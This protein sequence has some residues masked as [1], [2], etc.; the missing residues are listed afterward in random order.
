MKRKKVLLGA[1]AI[2]FFVMLLLGVLKVVG[3]TDTPEINASE[4][5]EPAG[6]EK[7]ELKLDTIHKDTDWY[8][9]HAHFHEWI[10]EEM[11]KDNNPAMCLVCHGNN[12]HAN[13]KMTRSILNMHTVFCA[14]ET[15]HFRFDPK[16]K[17]KYGFRWY[18]GSEAIQASQRHYGT[19]YDAATG[20]V[21]MENTLVNFKI[22]PFLMWE[23]KYYMVNLRQDAPEAKEYLSK[24]GTYSPEEQAAIKTK[25]HASIETKGRECSECHSVNTVIPFKKLGFDDERVK[26]LTGLNIVGMVDKYQKFYI[27]DIF[28]QKRMYDE[29]ALE[30]TVGSAERSEK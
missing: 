3:I 23:G 12:P 29:S 13:A 27:P 19:N 14:C 11:P 16:E 2:M 1:G 9:K 17:G 24:K 22:T 15:C 30:E 21:L 10:E 26:D 6:G 4:K 7:T 20:R 5:A 8:I 28:K 18:D 25:I